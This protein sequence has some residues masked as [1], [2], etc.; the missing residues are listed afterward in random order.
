MTWKLEYNSKL[1]IIESVLSGNVSGSDMREITSQSVSLSHEHGVTRFLVDASNQEQAG[2]VTDIY[3]LPR[4]YTEE[5][6]DRLGYLAYVRPILP[7]L[8]KLAQF[9]ENVCVNRGWRMES[10]T[11]YRDA[12][13]WLLRQ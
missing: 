8:Q 2:T 7:D 5:S 3:E 4:Q 10:F 6:V 1:G 9:F 13:G 11:N 12:I